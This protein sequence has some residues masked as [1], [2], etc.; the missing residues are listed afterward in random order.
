M[1]TQRSSPQPDLVTEASHSAGYKPPPRRGAGASIHH[2]TMQ[3]AMRADQ[4]RKRTVEGMSAL[5]QTASS[6]PRLR[7]KDFRAAYEA[8]QNN[9]VDPAEH[10]MS[11][12]RVP[13]Q[14]GV[15]AEP[16]VED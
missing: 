16:P 9:D 5:H 2:A 3:S 1:R 4:G 10:R 14:D 7:A 8:L 15:A 12:E 13:N 6:T 11:F